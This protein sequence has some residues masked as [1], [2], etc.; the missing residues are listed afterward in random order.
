MM[1]TKKISVIAGVIVFILFT[2]SRLW[3]LKIPEPYTYSIYFEAY[4]AT[5]EIDY[6]T[7]LDGIKESIISNRPV[8]IEI[9]GQA[10]AGETSGLA[11]KRAAYVSRWLKSEG[12]NAAYTERAAVHD[13]FQVPRY[14]DAREQRRVTITV[15]DQR[16]IY[17]MQDAK[18]ISEA[19]KKKKPEAYVSGVVHSFGSVVEG[20]FVEYDF[21]IRNVGDAELEIIKVKPD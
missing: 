18:R 10:G 13:S 19:K 2:G 15:Y 8:K 16:I 4:S 11:E 6:I 14:V 17:A 9:E 1:Q 5:P 3:A 21:N 20:S 7:K 12:I